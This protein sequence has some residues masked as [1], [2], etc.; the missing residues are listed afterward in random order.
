MKIPFDRVV[1]FILP[2]VSVVAG[3]LSTWLVTNVGVLGIFNV[4]QSSLEG[5]I[6]SVIIFAITTGAAELG[7]SQWLKGRHIELTGIAQ[8]QVLEKQFSI[9]TVADDP[10]DL[11]DETPDSPSGASAYD[12]GV[13]V[14]ESLNVDR[15]ES[16]VVPDNPE[17]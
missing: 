10:N 7:R 14:S 2:Y 15:P 8:E 5:V 6:T 13:D 12:D 1:T 11:S 4:T 17:A 9:P 16:G 3:F